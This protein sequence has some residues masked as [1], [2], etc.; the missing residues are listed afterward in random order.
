MD[1]VR[2]RFRE[3][4]DE[5]LIPVLEF[6]T[7]LNLRY[8]NAKAL[9]LFKMEMK[10]IY[11]KVNL[12]TLVVQEQIELVHRGL[13]QLEAG[14]KP[15]SLSLRVLRKDNVQV[16]TQVYSDKIESQGKVIGFVAYLVDLSRRAAFEEK[17]EQRKDLLEYIVEYS[18]F[19]A[20]GIIDDKYRL[21]YVNDK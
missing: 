4:A 12:D 13:V 9:E 17:V 16:P 11:A 15:T 14:E 1:K 2:K 7:E 10:D 8:A 19:I 5:M 6:D 21:E 20:I 18:T 3:V